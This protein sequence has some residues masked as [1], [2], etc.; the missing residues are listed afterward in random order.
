MKGFY[1]DEDKSGLLIY[2]AHYL[3]FGKEENHS[4]LNTHPL[5]THQLLKPDSLTTGDLDAVAAL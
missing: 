2:P 5:Q 4:S 1:K 3:R